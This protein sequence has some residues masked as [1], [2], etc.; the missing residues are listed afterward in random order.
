M[1]RPTKKKTSSREA[2]AFP[3]NI[4]TSVVHALAEGGIFSP[5]DLLMHRPEDVA[6]MRGVGRVA[7]RECFRAA[8][9]EAWRLIDRW[10]RYADVEKF[11]P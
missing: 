7:M 3:D 2:P 4:T 5:L 6:K 9:A 10:S 1:T 8:T 11:R